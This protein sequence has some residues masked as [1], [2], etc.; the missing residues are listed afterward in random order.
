MMR[1]LLIGASGFIGAQLC[2]SPPSQIELT[3]TYSSTKIQASDFEIIRLDILDRGLN[4]DN[5]IVGF[6]CII[7]AARPS[8]ND[9]VSR[10]KIAK[11]TRLAF[12]EM[13]QAIERCTVPPH[14]VAIHGSL[15]Y[16]DCSDRLVTIHEDIKPVGFAESYAI[17][18]EP[19]RDYCATGNNCAIIRA[20]WVLGDGSWYHELYAR[21]DRVPL[22][23]GGQHWMSIVTVE[24]LAEFVWDVVLQAKHGVL[25]PRLDYRCR[26][27]DFAQL[28]S[29]VSDKKIK[30]FGWVRMRVFEVQMRKSIMASIR[31][32]DGSNGASESQSECVELVKYLRKIHD[33]F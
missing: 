9:R 8:G 14:L 32:D 11:E 7:V 13:V 18:E 31:L 27:R 6:D 25:H 3:G 23:R 29:K 12:S 2:V 10:T 4:W 26:Q 20:P 15:S 21:P 19:I 5:V 33:G 24:G 28:V 30:K 16:G 17:A 22:L 1:V